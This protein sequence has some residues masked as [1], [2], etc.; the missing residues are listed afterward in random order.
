MSKL[1][2]ID[3]ETTGVDRQKSGIYQ[4]AGIIECDGKVQEEFDFKCDIFKNDTVDEKVMIMNGKTLKDLRSY[5]GP[6]ETFLRF[7]ELLSQYVNKFDKED[8]FIVIGYFADFDA[9]MLRTWF[10]K[11]NDKYFGSWFWHPWID[12]AQLVAYLSIENRH[13]FPNFKLI[14]VTSL[15]G[16]DNKEEKYHDALFGV[17]VTRE[18]YVKVDTV[19]RGDF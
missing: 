7:T 17:R 9:E 10:S 16:V 2:F 4:I 3:T 18:L 5:P 14:T 8:K 13:L 1:L 6:E 12:V 11:N 19:L 15:L